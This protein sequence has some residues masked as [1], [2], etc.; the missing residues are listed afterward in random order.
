MNRFSYEQLLSKRIDTLPYSIKPKHYMEFKKNLI[1]S[2]NFRLTPD[3]PSFLE[4]MFGSYKREMEKN[5][6]QVSPKQLMEHTIIMCSLM[7]GP[8]LTKTGDDFE[9]EMTGENTSEEYWEILQDPFKDL[10]NI[11]EDGVL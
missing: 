10:R 2:L 7:K 8:A 11:P 5:H 9:Y 4:V 1:K 3:G 6:I